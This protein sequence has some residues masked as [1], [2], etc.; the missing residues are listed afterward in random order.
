MRIIDVVRQLRQQRRRRNA[1]S[2][3]QTALRLFGSFRPWAARIHIPVIDIGFLGKILIHTHFVYSLIHK[4]NRD[5]RSLFFVIQQSK[6][7]LTAY[8]LAITPLILPIPFIGNTASNELYEH[9]QKRSSEI[10]V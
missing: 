3:G 5:I 9:T 2:R 8:S 10:T 4:K 6:R 1:A 7:I